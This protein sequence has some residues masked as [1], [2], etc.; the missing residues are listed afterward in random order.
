MRLLAVG[1]AILLSASA[2][3]AFAQN[4]T[5]VGGISVPASAVPFQGQTGMTPPLRGAIGMTPPIGFPASRQTAL[6]NPFTV[7]SGGFNQSVITPQTLFGSQL[8]PIPGGI[9][10][11]VPTATTPGLSA[12]NETNTAGT[13]TPQSAPFVTS[14]S[15][16]YGGTGYG[17]TTIGPYLQGTAAII[18]A[19]G[20]VGL[21]DSQA[22]VNYSVANN[23][24]ALAAQQ[25]YA[26]NS[27]KWAARKAFWDSLKPPKKTPEQ[28]ADRARQQLPNRLRPS[29]LDPTTGQISWPSLLLE[30]EFIPLRS[31][32]D[33]LFAQRAAGGGLAA[34][35]YISLDEAIDQLRDALTQ[36]V[37]EYPVDLFITADRFLNSLAY[38]A[39]LVPARSAAVSKADATQDERA[40]LRPPRLASPAASPTVM[41]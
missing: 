32:V 24:H 33:I 40:E 41:R 25:W 3:T 31:E 15:G 7:V 37:K 26:L 23:N 8:T 22:A 36:R 38:E 35:G 27:A 11:F 1:F 14:D 10:Q 5:Q 39:T 9:N 34:T 29:E 28:W 6:G 21:A 12:A 18:R 16:G 4:R 13:T 17:G 2:A 20:Y 30:S 19:G